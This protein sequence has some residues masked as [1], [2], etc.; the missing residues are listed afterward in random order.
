[1]CNFHMLETL[2]VDNSNEPDLTEVDANIGHGEIVDTWAPSLKAN[3]NHMVNMADDAWQE[4]AFN[5]DHCELKKRIWSKI[6]R[7]LSL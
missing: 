1:M 4:L 3:D 5:A 7:K 6:S 2:N